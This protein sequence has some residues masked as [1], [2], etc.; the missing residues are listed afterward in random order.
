MNERS[1]GARDSTGKP[2][3]ALALVLFAALAC[4]LPK[5]WRN[6]NP[7]DFDSAK[8]R[9]GDRIDRGAMYADLFIKRTLNGKSNEEVVQLLGE[10]DKKMNVEGREVWLYRVEVR[11]EWS[12]PAFPVSFD[13]KT[14]RAFAGRIKGG[15]MSMI[16]DEDERR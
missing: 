7:R 2:V 5:P 3:A 8:W 9:N 11:G 6:Y 15:T 16:I 4:G 14:G 1:L 10:P 13:P 12:R